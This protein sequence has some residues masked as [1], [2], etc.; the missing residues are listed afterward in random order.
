MLSL[1]LIKFSVP[2]YKVRGESAILE[3][4]YELENEKLYALKW[5]KDNEEFYRYVPRSD[6]VKQS[7]NVEGVRVEVSITSSEL[8]LLVQ[9]QLQ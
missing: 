6:S 5:Y 8:Y 7:Y 3:C 4:K 9:V 2:Q 1:K